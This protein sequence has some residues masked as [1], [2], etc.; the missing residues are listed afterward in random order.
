[1]AHNKQAAK[2]KEKAAGKPITT[3]PI[4]V[5][6]VAFMAAYILSQ[7]SL[8]SLVFGVLAFFILV[9]LLVIEFVVSGKQEG[10]TKSVMEIAVAVAVIALFWVSLRY[11]L[12]TSDPIDVVPSC[13]MLP[14]LQRGDLIVLQ[15]VNISAI[16]APVVD[17]SRQ[18]LNAMLSSIQSENLVCLSYA[19]GR[20]SQIEQPG[21]TL[22]LFKFRGSAYEQVSGQPESNLVQYKCG[23][24]RVLFSN[25]TVEN[26]AYTKSISIGGVEL[27]ENLNNSV[28]VYRTVPGDY[29][30]SLGDTFIVHRIYA[31]LNASG[32]YYLLT[33]GD[34]NPSLDIQYMNLPVNFSMV[35]G[36]SILSIPY[37]GYMKIILSGQ[38]L[39]PQGCNSTVLH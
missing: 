31:V 11:I 5:L 38:L 10:Y 18:D 30:Y 39:Q 28:V 1:M 36:R 6:F 32:S 2:G 37:L 35:G 21:S 29:F 25:G 23:Y 16:K 22:G 9:V 13:S 34:N 15:G 24:Q 12:N 19:N 27:S 4:Y 17:V 14:S 7:G 20:V 8:L 3:W 26:E 33:K